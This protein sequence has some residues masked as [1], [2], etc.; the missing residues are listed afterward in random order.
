MNFE[1]T[2]TILS[3]L[4]GIFGAAVINFDTKEL[5]ATPSRNLLPIENVIAS[6]SEEL[7]YERNMLAD[8]ECYDVVEN[9]IMS[10]ANHYYIHYV[11]PH[12]DNVVIYVVVR[13]DTALPFILRT[14]EQAGDAMRN[15]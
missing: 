11:V 14:L 10:T 9:M 15:F 7:C 8:L 2:T 1:R 6:C 3:E 4:P 13:R 5:I 12:F